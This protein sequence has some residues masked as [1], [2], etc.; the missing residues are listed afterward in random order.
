M[1]TLYKS[2]PF[3]IKKV[4]EDTRK[5]IAVISKEVMDDE[6]D[7]IVI[8]GIDTSRF[9]KGGIPLMWSHQH[10]DPPIGKTTFITKV[11]DELIA[12]FEYAT[13]EEYS[14]ADTIYKLTKGG[15]INSFSITVVPKDGGLENMQGGRF[16]VKKSKLLEVSATSVPANEHANVLSKALTKAIDDKFLDEVEAGEVDLFLKKIEIEKIENDTDDEF[17]SLMKQIKDDDLNSEQIHET[18]CK[19]CGSDLTC[20]ICNQKHK[21]MDDFEWV[22]SNLE[23]PSPDKGEADSKLILKSIGIKE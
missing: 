4:E 17:D 15:Y 5:I 16:M 10:Y 11:E 7:L 18:I 21:S 22:L 6:G 1:K 20:P 23:Q 19:D 12:E 8:D 14:F 2:I 9:E 13:A 3:Q